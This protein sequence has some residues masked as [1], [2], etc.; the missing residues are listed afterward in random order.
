MSSIHIADDTFV[1]ASP[2]LVAAELSFESDWR[3]WWP[4]LAVS[5]REDRAEKGIRWR[6]GD[7]LEGTMEVWLE[8]VLDGTML[9]YFLHAEPAGGLIPQA[10]E[11]ADLNHK[12]RVAG[13]SMALEVKFRA[14]RGRRP[15]EPSVSSATSG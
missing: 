13:R 9:H 7:A 12:R 5:V 15:G 6:V 8:P 11:L 14:E 1:A 2:G 4:D 10:G 3:R